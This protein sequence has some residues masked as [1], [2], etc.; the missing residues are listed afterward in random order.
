MMMGSPVFGSLPPRA[1]RV[2]VE[3]VPKLTM[4]T[5]SPSANASPIAVNTPSTTESAAALDSDA[6]WVATWQ[7]RSDSLEPDGTA[8][9]SRPRNAPAPSGAGW[10][11]EAGAY[12][13]PGLAMR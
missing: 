2:L 3:D 6:C 11:E 5:V 8:T 13:L 12:G 10:S 9:R 4:A 7:E 1:G